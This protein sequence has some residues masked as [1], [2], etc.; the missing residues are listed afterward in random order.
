MPEKLG[1]AAIVAA[2]VLPAAIAQ[3]PAATLA[4][5]VEEGSGGRWS[6]GGAE[7]TLW[8][9]KATLLGAE[10]S[11]GSKR[12]RAVQ[13]VHWK[14]RWSEMWRGH[15]AF[16]TTLEHGSTLLNIGI[17]GIALENLDAELPASILSGLLSG[18]LAR[19]G[20]TG[21]LEA[22]T[23]SFKCRWN[24]SSC[25]GEIEILW[26]NAGVT[27]ISDTALGSYRSRI[28]GEGQS[29]H[30]DLATINGRLQIAGSGDVDAAGMRF[31]GQASA[32]GNEADRLEAQLRTL[33]RRGPSPGVYVLEYRTPGRPD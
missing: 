33:G 1:I 30:F 11:A 26:N 13:S 8:K 15:L 3:W 7:G 4:G 10:G 14:L 25:S 29:V 27:E 24:A 18:P 31:T 23:G 9:G 28:V 20:W 6:L 5:W 12:W 22:R 16:E 2:L 21:T 17:G 32:K 19:Y